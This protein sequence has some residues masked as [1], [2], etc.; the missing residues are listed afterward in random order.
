MRLVVKIV[1]CY[2]G[3]GLPI[4]EMIS[5][6]NIGLIQAVNRFEPQKVFEARRLTEEP[7]TLKELADEFGV[8]RE[9]VR[10][11]DVTS[12]VKVP[13]DGQEPR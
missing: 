13:E 6:G 3:Y 1:M 5:E 7:I 2:R 8:S 9:R 11:I 4:S 12:F 10:Q